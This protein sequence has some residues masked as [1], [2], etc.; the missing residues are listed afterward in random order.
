MTPG[1]AD[2]SAVGGAVRSLTCLGARFWPGVTYWPS[3]RIPDQRRAPNA[4]D[5]RGPSCRHVAAREHP[6]APV[7]SAGGT[8]DIGAL[9]V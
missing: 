1:T 7:P 2:A 9:V 8:V 4:I 3:A 6:A 5:R